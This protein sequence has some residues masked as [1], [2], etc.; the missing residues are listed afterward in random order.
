M[1]GFFGKLPGYGD[2]LTRGLPPSFIRP[3]D[4]WLGVGLAN[5]EQRLGRN[6]AERF[7]E[8]PPLRFALAPG[9]CG[10]LPWI[11]VLVPSHDRVG[12]W[13]PLTVAASPENRPRWRDCIGDDGTWAQALETVA[14]AGARG[15]LDQAALER[16]IPELYSVSDDGP[17][18]ASVLPTGLR[19][20]ALEDD[21]ELRDLSAAL[22]GDDLSPLA[23]PLSLWWTGALAGLVR[24]AY[25]GLPSGQDFLRLIPGLGMR[26]A[27]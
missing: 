19:C 18:V 17:E 26:V 6:W 8:D 23:G 7:A 11:G 9:T 2:F 20:L 12:R 14:R 21:R 16:S 22:A 15:G 25:S 13:Y 27:S 1:V 3:W 5:V 24:Y 10:P 4:A